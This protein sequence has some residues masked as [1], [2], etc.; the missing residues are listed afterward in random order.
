M[1]RPRSGLALAFY[2]ELP[3][4]TGSWVNVLVDSVVTSR[5]DEAV[6]AL[7]DSHALRRLYDLHAPA[8]LGYLIRYLR[9]DRQHAEDVV[10]E[11]ILR[12]WRHPEVQSPGGE[13]SR[14]WLLTVARRIAIDNVRSAAARVPELPDDHL[15]ER[16]CD[17]DEFERMLDAHEVRNALKSLPCKQRLAL[18][19]IYYRDRSVTEAA[20]SLGVPPG[21]IKS[22]AFYALSALREALRA[23]GF[24]FPPSTSRYRSNAASVPP[25]QTITR[26]SLTGLLDAE[27]V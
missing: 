27:F 19:E 25:E 3:G 17:I 2:G 23:S 15:D 10:Q 26:V 1:D 24:A 8:L 20:E 11:T 13:W 18:I 22:R 4:E 21:T 5:V 7:A 14:S 6:P 16:T 12:A 9:G